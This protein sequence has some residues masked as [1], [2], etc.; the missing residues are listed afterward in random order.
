MSQSGVVDYD[1]HQYL[2]LPA[3]CSLNSQGDFASTLVTLADGAL[4]LLWRDF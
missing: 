1:F 4:Y 3:L 2:S